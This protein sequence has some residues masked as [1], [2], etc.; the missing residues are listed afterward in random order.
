MYVVN[1]VSTI[2]WSDFIQAA[3]VE[4]FNHSRVYK[5]HTTDRKLCWEQ[6]QS[7]ENLSEQQILSSAVIDEH[8]KTKTLRCSL[9]I[10]VFSKHTREFG[11]TNWLIGAVFT[12]PTSYL[13]V[14]SQ[15]GA[16]RD[17]RRSAQLRG[18]VHKT[19]PGSSWSLWCSCS[20]HI[21]MKFK[22]SRLLEILWEEAQ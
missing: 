6:C 2:S 19:P 11:G 13:D 18:D 16:S 21:V 4:M 22:R 15:T 5:V 12:Y 3:D 7:A 8:G 10:K 20:I 9:A 17:P 1:Q 14:F